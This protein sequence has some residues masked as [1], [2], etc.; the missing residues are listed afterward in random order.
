MDR[1]ND[2]KVLLKKWE[3]SFVQQQQ[4][5]PNKVMN[6][7]MLSSETAT[8]TTILYVLVIK[9]IPCLSSHIRVS[10]L[11][12]RC[13]LLLQEDIDNAPEDT[14]SEFVFSGYLFFD[15]YVNQCE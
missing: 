2:V 12:K 13:S 8:S 3:Q 15:A 10:L 6:V 5:K 1:Y 9:T 14:K 7:Y 4:R 11:I